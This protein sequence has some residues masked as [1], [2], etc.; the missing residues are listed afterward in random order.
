MS[1]RTDVFLRRE[2]VP[3]HQNL[4]FADQEA[5]VAAARGDLEF[6]VCESCGFVYNGAFELS[7]MSY[8]SDYDND[9]TCSPL[10]REHIDGLIGRL[11]SQRRGS[12]ATPFRIVEVGCGQGGFLKQLVAA[13]G[14][15][16]TGFGFDPSYNGPLSALDGRVLFAQDYYGPDHANIRADLVVCRHV[17]E[18]VPEPAKLLR[19]V[20]LATAESPN[21]R[22]VFETPCVEWILRNFVIWDFFYEHCSLFSKDSLATAFENAGF[23]VESVDHVFQGQYLWLEAIPAAGRKTAPRGGGVIVERARVFEKTERQQSSKIRAMAER[24]AAEGGLAL[25]GAGAKGVTLANLIDPNRSLLQC[26]VDL[27]PHK[28]GRFV[29]GTGHPIVHHSALQELGIMNAILMNP[30]YRQENEEL[31]GNAGITTNLVEFEERSSK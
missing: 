30:N 23:V 27:N 3:V 6:R 17:I 14:E 26:I 29:A 2:R 24:L 15:G 16:A 25:W 21:A 9:Q 31:L 7:R 1:R 13:A 22:V 4:L 8:G 12:T 10:F 19:S 18:H 20:R 28:Q 11:A 5:A